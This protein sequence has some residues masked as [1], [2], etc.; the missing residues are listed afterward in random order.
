MN[1]YDYQLNQLNKI[2]SKYIS[3]NS[4]ISNMDLTPKNQNDILEI[5]QAMDR[6]EYLIDYMFH[7]KKSPE[8]KK[9]ESIIN[10]FQPLIMASYF[11]EPDQSDLTTVDA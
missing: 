2:K 6:L 11:L 9:L 3:L 1:I 8:E 10:K 5:T 7:Q 4:K